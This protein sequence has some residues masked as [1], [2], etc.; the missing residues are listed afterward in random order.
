MYFFDIGHPCYGQLT[1]V[2]QGIRRLVSCYDIA[3]SSLDLIMVTWLFEN[4]LWPSAG[5]GLDCGLISDK[6]VIRARLFGSQ[7]MLTQD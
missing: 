7:L 1:P 6:L 3:H 5:F 4:D 2:K